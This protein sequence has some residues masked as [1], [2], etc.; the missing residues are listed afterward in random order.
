M[1]L[2]AQQSNTW[3]GYVDWRNRPALRTRHGGM[4]AASFVLVVEI[5][6]NLAYLAN[7]SNLVLY[8]REYMHM[9]PSRSANNVTNFM[10]TAFLL[11]LLGGFLSDAFF[12]TY[13]IYIISAL[14]EFLGLIVLT[15]QAKVPSLKPPHECDST[16]ACVEVNGG[17]AAMLFGGLYLV[18]LG[19]GGIKG[20]LPSHGGEQFDEATPSGRKQRSTFF[21]Y[22][23]FCLSCGALIAVTF[24]VWVEDNKGWEWGFAIS[25]IAIFVSI[26]L[27]LAGSSAYRNKIPTGSPLTTILKV[28][29]SATLNNCIYKNSSSAVVNMAPSPSNTHSSG[30]RKESEE[31]ETSK[32]VTQH[33]NETLTASLRFLNKAVSNSSSSL[34]CTVQQVEDVKI[35]LKVLP[36]FACTIMLNCCLAQ[37]STFSVEQAAT[38]NTKLGSLKVPPASLP[39]F[40]VLFIMFIA[41]I[42]DH[43]IIPYA[44]KATKSEMGITHLQRIG[45]G[46]FLSIVAMAVAAVVEVKRK[47]VATNSGLIDENNG[48]TTKPLPITFLWIAFQYL[49]L[50][51]ADLFTL[52]G[53]LEFFFSE[54][55]IRMRSLATSLSWASLAMGYYLSSV[56]VSIV[57]SATGSSNHKPW[58]S[59]ANLNHYHL[60]RFYWLM[61]VLS[62]LNFLHYLFWATRYKYRGTCAN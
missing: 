32:S 28:L 20:S 44:R 61:C 41:P 54:A 14:I 43:I 46:L 19:V 18:A 51:S 4:L 29:V 39:V 3:E 31:A 34:Q 49:F 23:V 57:N 11:A 52:A 35:V 53:L 10:G 17:K 47:R 30:N 8:L 45:I 15:I 9:S 60:E 26:P 40:P 48:A 13:H 55:P 25:T 1:E 16:A 37:L 6:E 59:G 5:L 58:L 27:F 24:V 62:G 33:D 42:Y 2:E 38:M 21:N 12:T 56:I 22:F 50:G 36:I 7:A